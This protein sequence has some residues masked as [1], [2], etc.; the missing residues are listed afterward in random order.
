ML[1]IERLLAKG[2]WMRR[3]HR[4]LKSMVKASECVKRLNASVGLR[5]AERLTGTCIEQ[6]TNAETYSTASQMGART[7]GHTYL[8]QRA[9]RTDNHL[10]RSRLERHA[11]SENKEHL[12]KIT[13][14]GA[15]TVDEGLQANIYGSTAGLRWGHAHRSTNRSKGTTI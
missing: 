12:N 3:D 5:V 7:R 1:K 6:R 13:E 4:L 11:E 9:V 15:S 10:R 2:N 8:A 14:E